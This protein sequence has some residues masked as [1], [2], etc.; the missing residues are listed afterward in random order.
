MAQALYQQQQQGQLPQMPTRYTLHNSAEGDPEH[1]TAFH[2]N[3]V[4]VPSQ[5]LHTPH[6]Q[7]PN[8]PQCAPLLVSSPGSLGGSCGLA[9]P[10]PCSPALC[11]IALRS[12][13]CCL[14]MALGPDHVGR[15]RG[16][17]SSGAPPTGKSGRQRATRRGPMDEMRQ[18]VRILVKVRR[19]PLL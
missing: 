13:L 10:L 19:L 7:D 17:M 15:C 5:G 3:M 6:P 1:P 2:L 16:P 18:L 11:L 12:L 8:F 9:P 4:P 14:P